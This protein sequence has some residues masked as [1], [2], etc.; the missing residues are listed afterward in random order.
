MRLR[1][2]RLE[3]V[4]SFLAPAELILDGDVSILIGPNGGG[5]TNLLDAT[6]T[7]IRRHLLW[8]YLSRPSQVPGNPRRRQLVVNDTL[9]NAEL[10]K[11]FAG[12]EQRQSIEVDLEITKRDIENMT[13]MKS[14]TAKIVESISEVYEHNPTAEVANWDISK[15]KEG[16][17][18]TYQII[19]G[20]IQKEPNQ[21][22]RDFQRY[23]NLFE[24]D[25]YLRNE[26]RLKSLSAPVLSMPT[27]RTLGVF[28]PNLSLAEFNEFEHK[29]VVDAATSRSPASVTS[30]AVGRIATRY[31]R[32]QE[33]DNTSAKEALHS[34]PQIQKLTHALA[35][36]GFTWNLRCINESRNEYDICLTKD[37]NSFSV[38]AA[39]AGEREL[40]TY[41]FAIYGLNVRDALI[42]VDEPEIHL[43]PRWQQSLLRLF[44]DLA[45]ETGNQFLLATHSPVFVS[46]SSIH[47]VSRVYSKNQQSAVIKLD[48]ENLPESKHLFS[49][50]NSLNNESMFFADKVVLVEGIS[51]RIFFTA[52]LR[53]LGVLSDNS[54]II[55]I[56]SVG[57]KKSFAQYR[58]ILAAFKIPHVLIADHDYLHDCGTDDIKKLFEIDEKSIE[59]ALSNDQTSTD[60]SALVE[61]LEDAITSGNT[62][63]LRNLW[64]YIKARRQRF[65]KNLDAKCQ[66]IVTEYIRSLRND[67]VFVLRQGKLE[68]YLPEGYKSK[69]L[70]KLID[71]VNGE[72]WELLPG[73]A[74]SELEEIAEAIRSL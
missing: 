53:K 42:I 4:R 2:V 66:E 38:N 6:I 7:A 32:L 51:D 9:Q 27:N 40:L 67:S 12:K 31:R 1:R 25:S 52:V 16:Q 70:N 43:H 74:R 71:L 44:E 11:H 68:D 35:S 29:R 50:V 46:P 18:F 73:S 26:A 45:A 37:A 3:N 69:D 64:T 57:G 61:R 55:E 30:L 22:H 34:D 15:L 24:A 21:Q 23:L 58:C 13:E 39:S 62:E 14:S 59:K 72:F 48:S 8:S 36:L 54:Q 20:V 60:G 65:R 33:D 28:L 19:D 41:L 49:I 63:D 17:R 47:Y 56:L 10:E 5:K